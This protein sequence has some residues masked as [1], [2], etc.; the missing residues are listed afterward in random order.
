MM[1]DYHV[2]VVGSG[3]TDSGV[4]ASCQVCHVDIIRARR[5]K[6]LPPLG[7]AGDVA[8]G[9]DSI[10]EAAR[11]TAAANGGSAIAAA[12]MP[13]T[14]TSCDGPAVRQSVRVPLPPK[15]GPMAKAYMP[16]GLRQQ[17]ALVE[18]RHLEFVPAPIITSSST[19]AAAAADADASAQPLTP[20]QAPAPAPAPTAVIGGVGSGKLPSDADP[21]TAKEP[22]P[23]SRLVLALNDHIKRVRLR[24]ARVSPSSHF[25]LHEPSI[26]TQVSFQGTCANIDSPHSF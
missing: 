3:R 5:R 12:F 20:A 22:M 8:A 6:D 14:N 26:T 23:A 24:D 19:D 18:R 17:V 25:D 11:G 9:S 7:H 15:T 10:G 13:V 1:P 4:H 2:S 16:P 21:A